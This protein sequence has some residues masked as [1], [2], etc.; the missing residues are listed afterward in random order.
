MMIMHL[1]QYDSEKRQLQDEV[2]SLKATVRSFEEQVLLK[3]YELFH[4]KERYKQKAE[5]YEAQ[6]KEHIINNKSIESQYLLLFSEVVSCRHRLKTAFKKMQSQK[7]QWQREKEADQ[8]TFFS[9]SIIK[10]N[11]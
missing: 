5:C 2:E 4:Q 11:V 7:F 8:W 10:T 9:P 6:V 1:L 3:E